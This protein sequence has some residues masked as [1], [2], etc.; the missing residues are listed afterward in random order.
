MR[1]M[2]VEDEPSLADALSEIVHDLGHETVIVHDAEA[3]FKVFSRDPPDAILLDVNLPGMSG[4]E[5]MGLPS[6]REAGIPIVVISGVLTEAQAR[7]AL[8]RGAIEFLTKPVSIER[9]ATVLDFLAPMA[10]E[11][12]P[13]LKPDRRPARRVRLIFDVL[14]SY[15]QKT[16]GGTCLELSSSGMKARPDEPLRRGLTV[17]LSFTLPDRGRPL[18]VVALVVRVDPDGAAFWFLDLQAADAGRIS[19]LVSQKSL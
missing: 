7:A 14:F 13:L 11:R 5:F 12:K 18:D 19:R 10:P 3:A 8:A 17:R 4:L 16:C 6:V 2:I 9:L 1:V 15:K